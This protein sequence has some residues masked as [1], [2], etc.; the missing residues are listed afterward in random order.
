LKGV[1]RGF[2]L[3]ET[4]IATGLLVIALVTLAQ[5]VSVGV[6]S[7]AAARARSATTLMAGQKLE[8][9]RAQPWAS[10]A[11]MRPGAVEY[12]DAGGRER[13]RG[14]SSPCGDAVYVRRMTIAPPSLSTDVLLIEVD[15]SL[16]GHGH[17]R[18]TM[19]TARAR[20]EP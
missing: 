9:L 10:I 13:C 14:A 19:V 4:I 11:A 15:V 2:S 8:H 17:G 6:Q 12:L 5:F 1:E 3:I 18:S 7:G 16:V 20:M